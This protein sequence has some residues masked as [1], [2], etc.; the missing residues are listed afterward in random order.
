[1]PPFLLC[2]SKPVMSKYKLIMG[3]TLDHVQGKRL[4][5]LDHLITHGFHLHKGEFRDVPL[6]VIWQ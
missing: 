2:I 4:V 6:F 3:K 1:M 5:H